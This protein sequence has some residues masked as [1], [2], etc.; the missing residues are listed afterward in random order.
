MSAIPTEQLLAQFG[1]DAGP[2]EEFAPDN[3]DEILGFGAQGLST[4]VVCTPGYRSAG[5]KYE[6]AQKVC[7]SLEQVIEEI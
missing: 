6:S 2:M 4:V 1:I 3:Y 5:V 7:F